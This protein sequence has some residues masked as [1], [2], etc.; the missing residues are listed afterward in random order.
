MGKLED[1][2]ESHK[3]NIDRLT[4]ERTNSNASP[5]MQL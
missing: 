2:A 1:E 3:R 4:R 5:T